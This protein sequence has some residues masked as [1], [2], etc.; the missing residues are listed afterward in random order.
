MRGRKRL[1]SDLSGIIGASQP[2][3]PDEE[4][5][6]LPSLTVDGTLTGRVQ[7]VRSQYQF[8]L[9]AKIECY[10]VGDTATEYVRAV[11][12]GTMVEIKGLQE[13]LVN[14]TVW[15]FSKIQVHKQDHQCISTPVKFVID[16]KKTTLRFV[17]SG[18]QL[19]QLQQKP[20]P[21][22]T[23]ADLIAL[24]SQSSSDGVKLL[25]ED[26][27]AVVTAKHLRKNVLHVTVMDGSETKPGSYA[28]IEI[29]ILTETNP[30]MIAV[31]KPLV[32]F[33]LVCQVD[34]QAPMVLT[35]HAP[36]GNY[37]LTG[38]Y[39]APACEKTSKFRDLVHP[40]WPLSNMSGRI[41]QYAICYD[42]GS[43]GAEILRSIKCVV[44]GAKKSSLLMVA[45]QETWP[46]RAE[47]VAQECSRCACSSQD[48]ML[49][50]YRITSSS[51]SWGNRPVCFHCYGV[52]VARR[53]GSTF[54]L[55]NS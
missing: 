9:S 25:H 46:P 31:G 3:V 26:L 50:I 20:I 22:R 41:R 8:M 18:E 14:G 42:C 45:C 27:L 36:D 5:L 39:E 51:Q 7:H 21:P 4:P 6:V 52:P 2:N 43:N 32:F 49:C 10:V 38:I 48:G 53:R 13:R 17:E 34:A 37:R 24:C 47:R 1:R 30:D 29:D 44:C 11:A 54:L 19:L 35:A 12:H 16:L 33:D 55:A 23:I 28:Q 40:T 15:E